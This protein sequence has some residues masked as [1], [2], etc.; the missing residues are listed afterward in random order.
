MN[1]FEKVLE[2]LPE[3]FDEKKLMDTINK[4][5]CPISLYAAKKQVSKRYGVVAFNAWSKN[6]LPSETPTRQ[7]IGMKQS[8]LGV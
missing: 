3:E 1:N 8:N 5:G 7:Y 4:I 2:S 6:K